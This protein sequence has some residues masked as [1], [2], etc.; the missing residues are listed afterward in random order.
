MFE[1]FIR[2]VAHKLAE[3][4]LDF[5]REIVLDFSEIR[6]GLV[7]VRLEAAAR[8]SGAVVYALFSAT[9]LTLLTTPLLRTYQLQRRRDLY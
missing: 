6:E 9:S 4:Q 1:T 8:R 5:I 7:L 2:Q 3:G